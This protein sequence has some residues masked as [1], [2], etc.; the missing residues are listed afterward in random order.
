MEEN[1]VSSTS[2]ATASTQQSSGS[3]SQNT[4]EKSVL[5]SVQQHQTLLSILVTSF[6][7]GITFLALIYPSFGGLLVAGIIG[8]GVWTLSYVVVSETIGDLTTTL[9]KRG[10]KD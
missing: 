1:R 2:S 8:L 3:Q 6:L 4:K 5:G 10:G 9:S 7:L